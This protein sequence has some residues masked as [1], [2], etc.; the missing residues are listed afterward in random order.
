MNFFRFFPVPR[1]LPAIL[2]PVAARQQSPPGR[3]SCR[4][5]AEDARTIRIAPDPGQRG[6]DGARGPAPR[7]IRLTTPWTTGQDLA[8][9]DKAEIL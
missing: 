1:L 8:I 7:R 3:A 4:T 5:N 6:E 9:T 2:T